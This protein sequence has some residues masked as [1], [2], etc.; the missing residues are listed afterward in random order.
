MS[1][2][3]D[4]PVGDPAGMR[5]KAAQVGHLCDLLAHATSRIQRA[6]AAMT[7]RCAAGDDLRDV[8]TVRSNRVQQAA[9]EANALKQLL[10]REAAELE[11]SQRQWAQVLRRLAGR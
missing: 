4:F 1:L 8:L 2:Q 11:Q 10:L 6:S 7:Y 5:E 9:D 3:W